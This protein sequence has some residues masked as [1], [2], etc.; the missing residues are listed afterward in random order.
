MK[1][2]KITNKNIFVKDEASVSFHVD[3]GDY[4]GT[5]ATV[6]SLIRQGIEENHYYNPETLAEALKNLET[7]LIHL[8]ED[9]DIIPKAKSL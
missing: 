3:S 2:Y 7:D 8:Q 6:V 5:I 4:F 9:Y 1:K